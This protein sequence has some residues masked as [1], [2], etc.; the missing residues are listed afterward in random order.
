MQITKQIPGRTAIFNNEEWLYFSGTSY[1]G[2]SQNSD[3][4]NFIIKGVQ[5]YGT[6]FGGSRL[7]N[8]RLEIFEAAE[9]ELANWTGA[10]AAL[11][12]SSG[13]LAGQLVV[14]MLEN[15]GK[16]YFAPGVHPALFGEGEYSEL[17][18]EN[19]T[20]FI[21]EKAQLT[22]H[23][24]VLFSNT[25]D[26]L[27]A[28]QFDFH[29]V[30]QLPNNIP[31]TLVLDDSHGMGITGKDGAGIFSKLK[32]PENVVLIVV[33]SLGKALSIPGGVILSKQHFIQKIWQS[34]YFGG[35]SPANPAYLQAF[36]QAQPLYQQQR[37]ILFRNS[38]F[39]KTTT[40]SLNLFQTFPAYP[41][42]YT[43]QN[44]LADFLK[45]HKVLISSF[46][47]PTAQSE[48][49]TR[50]V[51]NAAHTEADLIQLTDLLKEFLNLRSTKS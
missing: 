28:R 11:T 25:L 50:I 48:I 13:T 7:S 51:L 19:W 6:N 43:L 17:D 31:I 2:L 47:Y 20:Q 33:A 15:S 14:K 21:L 37:Q 45:Q 27:K 38:A 42:F 30:Q 34:P 46:A 16:F 9:N 40:E 35:A 18:F 12:V 5:Q 49:I 8:L 29:W 32:T 3:F 44:A 22:K 23:P 36:L 26:P 41:V 4:Q 24:L 10:E 1:L 39:F